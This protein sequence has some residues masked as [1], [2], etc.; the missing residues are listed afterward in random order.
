MQ[1]RGCRGSGVGKKEKSPLR[2]VLD[3]NILISALLF[4]GELAGVVDLW[5]TGRIVPVV[6]KETFDEF[7]AVLE[8]PKFRL[9]KEEIRVLIEEETLPFFEVVDSQPSHSCT[10]RDPEDEKFLACASAA[11]AD[12]IVSGDKDLC[13]MGRKPKCP[14]ITAARLLEIFKP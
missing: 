2:I 5:K 9:K 7:R 13:D 11:S 1:R 3:T 4:K 14:V 12:F 6:T 10:C 8:Y